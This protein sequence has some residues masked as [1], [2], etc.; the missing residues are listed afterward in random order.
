M[1]VVYYYENAHLLRNRSECTCPSAI[2][3]KTDLVTKAVHC[4]VKHAI[5]LK[6]KIPKCLDSV[7]LILLLNPPKPFDIGFNSG[8]QT[9][10]VRIIHKQN[11]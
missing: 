6:P 3:Y 11:N 9:I 4:R 10:S 7:D 1:G 8:K 2:Y 5:N